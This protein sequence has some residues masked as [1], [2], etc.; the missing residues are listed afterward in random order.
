MI[1]D[2]RSPSSV[3]CCN[4]REVVP[5]WPLWL[6]WRDPARPHQAP[7]AAHRSVLESSPGRRSASLLVLRASLFGIR[8]SHWKL[9]EYPTI[10]I[11]LL[12]YCWKL[13][14]LMFYGSSVLCK[15]MANRREKSSAFKAQIH[16]VLHWRPDSASDLAAEEARG[17]SQGPC[18]SL[19]PLSVSLPITSVTPL[20]TASLPHSLAFLT[21]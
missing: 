15:L 18:S 10:S 4:R 8:K 2:L 21:T 5:V 14:L 19:G 9:F 16:K 13:G 7:Q 11:H 17:W 3:Y 12:V 1:C 20:P 6:R